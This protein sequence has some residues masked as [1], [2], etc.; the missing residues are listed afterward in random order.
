MRRAL[1][2][3]YMVRVVSRL[4]CERLLCAYLTASQSSY[5]LRCIRLFITLTYTTGLYSNARQ[6]KI[7]RLADAYNIHSVDQTLRPPGFR[8]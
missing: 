6:S 8:Y 4:I 3:L 7:T 1:R 5:Y 2:I